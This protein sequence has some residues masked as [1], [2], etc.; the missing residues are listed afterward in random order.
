MLEMKLRSAKKHR[1]TDFCADG[2]LL[3]AERFG[4]V[5]V[6]GFPCGVDTEATPIRAHMM[7]AVAIQKKDRRAGKSV[8]KAGSRT[9]SDKVR[10]LFAH[11]TVGG[12]RGAG[13]WERE[14]RYDRYCC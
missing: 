7:S 10:A 8:P 4:G 13:P 14:F 1:R 6:S 2:D 5:E 12:A 11:G 9:R 3:V